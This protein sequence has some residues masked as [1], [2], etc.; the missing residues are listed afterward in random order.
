MEIACQEINRLTLEINTLKNEVQ[1]TRETNK[2]IKEQ[3]Q[4]AT[5]NLKQSL[6]TKDHAGLS[7]VMKLER[8]IK[9]CKEQEQRF[10]NILKVL[11]N[12]GIDFQELREELEDQ[13]D[14]ELT[15]K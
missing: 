3:L 7:Y 6:S 13:N 9:E 10:L 11:Y 12:R 14:T 5:S 8:K 4:Q 1:E 15:S 2:S